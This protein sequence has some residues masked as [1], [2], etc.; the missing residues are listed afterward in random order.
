MVCSVA[1]FCLVVA[2]IF[3]SRVIVNAENLLCLV[4]QQPKFSHAYC[5]RLMLFNGSID[6]MNDRCVA[7]MDLCGWLEIPNFYEGEAQDV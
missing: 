7:N 2:Q 4:I 1:V 5:M 6:N 3:L